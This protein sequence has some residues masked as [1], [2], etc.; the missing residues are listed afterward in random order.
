MSVCGGSKA[1]TE[2]IGMSPKEKCVLFLLKK[3]PILCEDKNKVDV[4]IGTVLDV[5]LE[6][7]V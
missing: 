5:S 3:R 1:D 7:Q 4:I 6:S 2:G